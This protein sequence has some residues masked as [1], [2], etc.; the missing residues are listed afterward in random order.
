[1]RKVML[2]ENI[3]LDGYFTGKDGDFSWAHR[4]PPDPEF[5]RFIHDNAQGGGTLLFGRKTYEM[6]ASFWPTKAGKDADPVIAKMMNEQAKVV[7][8]KSLKEASW[9]NARLV[10]T[11]PVK[12]V[13]SLQTEA[14][15]DLLVMGSGTIVAQLAR[16][17]LIDRVQLIVKPIAIGRGRTLFEGLEELQRYRL[18]SARGF[19]VS[20]NTF[21]EY[22]RL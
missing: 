15:P 2:F 5:Q 21:V 10:K 8:S 17:G 12:E 7:F 1:M 22:A 9:H 3:T 20:G 14:G 16:A 19:P 11:D 13:Q 4:D 18:V 6:M